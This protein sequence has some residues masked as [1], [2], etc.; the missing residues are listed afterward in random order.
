ME[1]HV[2]QPAPV[3]TWLWTRFFSGIANRTK[4]HYRRYRLEAVNAEQLN[5]QAGTPFRHALTPRTCARSAGFS[6]GW[7]IATR[8]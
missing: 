5:V 1:S 2:V 8:R 3:D 7:P 4:L 6:P